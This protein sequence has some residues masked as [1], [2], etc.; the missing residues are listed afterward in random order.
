MT[1]GLD[2]DFMDWI[3]QTGQKC[4]L[5]KMKVLLLASSEGACIV[6]F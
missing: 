4:G 6:S 3:L 2:K 5:D 1:Y